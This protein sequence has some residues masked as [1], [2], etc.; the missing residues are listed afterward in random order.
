MTCADT[1]LILAYQRLYAAR[2]ERRRAD[3][4]AV[5]ARART[6]SRTALDRSRAL[7]TRPRPPYLVPISKDPPT[8][9]GAHP[10]PVVAYCAGT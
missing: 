4:R 10:L 5:D 8:A 7:L 9:I 2:A 6:D 3:D 1:S